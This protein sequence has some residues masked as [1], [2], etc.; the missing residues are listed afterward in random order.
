MKNIAV[1]FGGKS[2]EHD[3]SIITGV[4][5]ING[6]NK[7]LYKIFPIYITK[8]GEWFFSETFTDT[9]VFFNFEEKKYNKVFFEAGNKT[10]FL[11]KKRKAF[12]AKK[13]CAIDCAILCNHGVNGE[14]GT[15]QGLLEL[16]NIP[17]TSSSVLGSSVT[18]DKVFMKK[19]FA[20]NDLPI[21]KYIWFLKSDYDKSKEKILTKIKKE[22]GFPL[23]VKPANLGS[24]IGINICKN[25]DE[26]IKAIDIAQSF[27]N[28]IIIEDVVHNLLEINCAVIGNNDEAEISKL[29]QPI[30]WQKFLSFD[31][32]YLNFSKAKLKQAKLPKEISQKIRN[33]SKLIFKNFELSGV[34]RIDFLFNTQSEELFVNEVNNIPGALSHHLFP[35]YTH[36]QFLT[37]LIDI[38]IEKHIEKQ[39]KTYCFESSVLNQKSL[40]FNKK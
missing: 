31:E 36:S 1:F 17:Y 12:V 37:K 28:K 10:L 39:S 34:V 25:I 40:N 21:T 27:D 35:G 16:C 23:I 3:I 13:L 9:N 14:D 4:Q 5:T 20:F 2:S 38:A 32:K 33:I 7:N 26:L 15:I 24:S 18:M 30:S 6:L 22:I 8:N 19:L 29:E 11:R